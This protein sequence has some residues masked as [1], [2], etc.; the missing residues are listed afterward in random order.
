MSARYDFP[1]VI[2]TDTVDPVTITIVADGLPV[3]VSTAT[4]TLNFDDAAF[5]DLTE[6]DM[7]V[8]VNVVTI[9]SWIAP[10][11]AGDFSYRMQFTFPSGD[12]KTYLYG[13]I[14]IRAVP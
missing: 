7:T 4:I 5:T 13:K 12:V 10:A 11:T 8:A 9:P 2:A 14:Q 6:A 3:D 1:C